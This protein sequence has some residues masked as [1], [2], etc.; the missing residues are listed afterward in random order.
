[1]VITEI[2]GSFRIKESFNI[3]R[4]GIVVSGYLL[5]GRP[6]ALGN[7]F[8]VDIDGKPTTVQIKGIERGN[9]D[10][11]GNIPWGLNLRFN[12]ETLQKIAEK[13]RIKEQLVEI[14]SVSDIK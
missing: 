6:P 4:I 12:D 13:N 5:E 8:I 9:F 3:S 10:S 14:F 1:M 11:D 7:Y 2:K